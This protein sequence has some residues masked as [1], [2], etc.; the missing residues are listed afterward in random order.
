MQELLKQALAPVPSKAAP[1]DPV[2]VDE[3]LKASLTQDDINTFMYHAE[4]VGFSPAEQIALAPD[5][6][7]AFLNQDLAKARHPIDKMI[8]LR[9]VSGSKTQQGQIVYDLKEFSY[10][11]VEKFFLDFGG[12]ENGD[13]EIGYDADLIECDFPFRGGTFHSFLTMSDDPRSVPQVFVFDMDPAREHAGRH[14]R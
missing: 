5:A 4:T 2:V 13:D 8:L 3:W 12:K 1:Y 10:N 9:L 14:F 11:V 6:A 7:L